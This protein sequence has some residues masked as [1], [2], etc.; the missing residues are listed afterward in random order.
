[1]I[2][3]VINMEPGQDNR[4]TCTCTYLYVVCQY[5]SRKIHVVI[6]PGIMAYTE[7]QASTHQL[8]VQPAA[9]RKTRGIVFLRQNTTTSTNERQ[10]PLNPS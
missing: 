1:V 10:Y 3:A 5:G 8:H 6:E 7:C 9:N 4:H 2:A